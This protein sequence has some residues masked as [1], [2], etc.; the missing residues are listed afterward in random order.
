MDI[1]EERS[2]FLFISKISEADSAKFNNVRSF[3]GRQY[4]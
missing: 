1:S 4:Y 3:G 2:K